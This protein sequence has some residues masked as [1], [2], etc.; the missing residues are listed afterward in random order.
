MGW[1]DT[2]RNGFRERDGGV[3]KGITE[4]AMASTV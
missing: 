2:L 4:W 3:D 1:V